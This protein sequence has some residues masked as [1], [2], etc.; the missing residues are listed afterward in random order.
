MS[1][2]LQNFGLPRTIGKYTFSCRPLPDKQRDRDTQTRQAHRQTNRQTNTETQTLT[3]R[4]TRH[5]RHAKHIRHT[6]HASTSSSQAHRHTNRQAS[7]RSICRT[8]APTGKC[9]K[10]YA[11]VGGQPKLSDASHLIINTRAQPPTSL[12][13]Q[14][15]VASALAPQTSLHDLDRS[16]CP[17][18]CE[19]KYA[20]YPDAP[21]PPGFKVEQ[22]WRR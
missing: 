11:C 6:R 21:A 17:W 3:R 20:S 8:L 14:D 18:S 13:A 22:P 2:V 7:R 19:K 9:E 12:A 15:C 5:D 1:L 16:K 10:K 4:H